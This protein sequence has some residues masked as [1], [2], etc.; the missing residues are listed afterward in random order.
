MFPVYRDFND[1]K[2]TICVHFTHTEMLRA[3]VIKYSGVDSSC[4]AIKYSTLS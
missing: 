2:T 1:V 4:A 3:S